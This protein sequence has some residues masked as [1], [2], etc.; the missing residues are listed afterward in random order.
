M[1]SW[2]LMGLKVRRVCWVR[3][4]TWRLMVHM[5]CWGSLVRMG[6]WHRMGL[7]V[8]WVCLVHRGSWHLMGRRVQMVCWGHREIWHLMVRKGRKRQMVHMG[9]L[10][11]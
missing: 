6:S 2:F 4:V 7:K 8:H 3:K 9:S 1:G 10:G 11:S 5:G